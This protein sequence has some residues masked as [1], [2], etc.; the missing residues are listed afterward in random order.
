[1]QRVWARHI[2]LN[3]NTVAKLWDG[4]RSQDML[5]ASI[6]S[7]M[8][9]FIHCHW[10]SSALNI[11][12]KYIFRFSTVYILQFVRTSLYIY[13]YELLMPEY[14]FSCPF[15]YV[16][17]V[18]KKIIKTERKCINLNLNNLTT[19][20]RPKEAKHFCSFYVPETHIMYFTRC[21]WFLKITEDCCCW[22]GGGVLLGYSAYI[23]SL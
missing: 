11:H 22:G 12:S 7:Y 19:T 18:K 17:S 1:M 20:H 5:M 9:A 23:I 4:K 16:H 21:C 6:L 3:S 2:W 14:S 15:C 10:I 8:Y 13:M